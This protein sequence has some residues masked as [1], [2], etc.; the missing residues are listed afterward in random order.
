MKKRVTALLLAALLLAFAAAS[1]GSN[2]DKN[3]ESG[4]EYDSR[5]PSGET[6]TV[7]ET[8]SFGEPVTQGESQ[9][10]APPV[11]NQS[12][13]NATF[14][15]ISKQLY[16]WTGVA[17][18]RT[19]TVISESTG[20]GWPKEGTVLNATGESSR[21]YRINYG[22]KVCYISKN[23]VCDYSLIQSFKE[24]NETVK[25]SENV[26]VRSLPSSSS[27]SS[28]RGILKKDAT[29]TRVGVG[30]GWSCILY[31]VVSETE[32][33]ASG[34]PVTET[35][36]YYISSDCIATNTGETSASAAS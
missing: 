17:T 26:K 20:C 33:D 15:D 8:N 6:Q 36:R 1:C 16:V 9:T 24:V 10:S 21:W 13:P 18:V 28:V 32:T 23:V 5:N 27:E 7:A 19:D 22:G 3:G 14:T 25:I 35:K 30:D 31:E 29:V 34:K 2:H 12:E 11:D 4:T